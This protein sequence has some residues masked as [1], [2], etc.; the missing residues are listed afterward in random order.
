MRFVLL[1]SNYKC[2][3]NGYSSITQRLALFQWFVVGGQR[4]LKTGAYVLAH[5]LHTKVDINW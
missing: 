2:H 4:W 5:V 1:E 3:I